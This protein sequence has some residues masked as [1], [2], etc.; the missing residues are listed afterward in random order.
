[1]E[2]KLQ[3]KPS[4]DEQTLPQKPL[5]GGTALPEKPPKGVGPKLRKKLPDD[6]KALPLEPRDGGTAP[7][8]KAPDK[9]VST[10]PGDVGN[11]SGGDI[12]ARVTNEAAGSRRPPARPSKN[13][14][15]RRSAWPAP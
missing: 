13:E 4:D 5:G 12:W 10:T 8:K 11:G 3:K 15:K 1:M 2:P 6:E 7:S 14:A 9:D